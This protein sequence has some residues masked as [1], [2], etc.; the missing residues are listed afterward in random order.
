MLRGWLVRWGYYVRKYT[1]PTPNELSFRQYK[2]DLR[3]ARRRVHLEAVEYQNAIEDEYLR[4]HQALMEQKHR[5][6]QGSFRKACFM[7]SYQLW[8]DADKIRR[9]N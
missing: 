9:D 8:K 3:S 7:N 4:R 2:K 6:R 5:E 1:P